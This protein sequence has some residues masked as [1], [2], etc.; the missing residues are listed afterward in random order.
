MPLLF[1]LGLLVIVIGTVI[2]TVNKRDSDRFI[3]MQTKA[4]YEHKK[5]AEDLNTF[6]NDPSENDGDKNKTE[7][8]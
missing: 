5:A 8:N 2:F 4:K 7:T 1:V 3:E 6:R